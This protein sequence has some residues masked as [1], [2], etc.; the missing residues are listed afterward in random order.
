MRYAYIRVSSV[1]QNIDRQFIEILKH[2]VD[3]KNIYIDKC[4]GKDFNRIEYLKLIKLLKKDDIL[5]IKSIDRLGRNY[6]MIVEEYRRITKDIQA[7]IYVIDMPILNAND[8]SL[9]STFISDI[10]LQI[11]SYVAENERK[12][13]K[14][15][16]AEGIKIAKEKGIKFGRPT[17]YNEEF[18]NILNNYYCNKIT[19]DDALIKL[20]ISKSTFYR[21]INIYKNE[22]VKISGSY[23]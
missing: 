22:A 1:S 19:I 12:N 7:K 15:R 18:I 2:D 10:V 6:N 4:S 23:A 5:Y 3:I 21:W 11:L 20:N 14:E 13:I 16:Q 8:D 9:L 17:K